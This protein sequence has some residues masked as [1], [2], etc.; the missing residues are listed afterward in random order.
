MGFHAI[1]NWRVLLSFIFQLKLDKNNMHLECFLLVKMTEFAIRRLLW[2]PWL[3]WLFG[4]SSS[5]KS[6]AYSATAWGVICD[7]VVT[8]TYTT[9]IQHEGWSQTDLT[10]VVPFTSIVGYV[11]FQFLTAASMKKTVYSHI[12]QCSFVDVDWRFRDAYCH[13]RCPDDRGCTHLSNVC[14]FLQDCTALCPRRL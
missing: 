1:L 3:P 2:L 6:A 4:E 14:L 13:H 5:A 9:T 12:A 10:S 7:D 11:R 8:Q